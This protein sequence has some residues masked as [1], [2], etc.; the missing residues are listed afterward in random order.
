M[1]THKVLFPVLI[2]S[3]ALSV[4]VQAGDHHGNG[5]SQVAA[6]PAPARGGRPAYNSG[7]GGFRYGSGRMIG[8][9]QRFSS[10]R[11][12]SFGQRQFTPGTVS[13]SYGAGRFANSNPLKPG[14]IRNNDSNSIG[15]SSRRLANGSNHVFSRH[16]ANWHSGW[17]RHHDHW[18]NGHRCR[19]VNGSWIVFDLGFF[20]WDG[21]PYDYY[22]YDYYN[23]YPY[24]YPY[25]YG[26]GYGPGVY[27]GVDPNN[28]ES[29]SSY[30]DSSNQNTG[31]TMAVAQERLARKG[32]YR[33]EIDGIFGP[34]TRRAIVRYQSD[35]GLRVT[36]SLTAETLQSLSLRREARD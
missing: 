3:A 7:S 22:A 4:S 21:Y 16:S 8:A 19:F 29:Q 17:D 11:G 14:A 5:G 2:F 34:A 9:S 36:G 30:Y 13:R 18:W 12:A 32:Y 20:P 31:S 25:D 26:Y 24:A 28:D 35:H 27:E 6:A 23:P 1:K 15:N 10:I 33:G